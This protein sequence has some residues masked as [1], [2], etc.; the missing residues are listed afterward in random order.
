MKSHYLIGPKKIIVKYLDEQAHETLRCGECG[1]GGSGDQ[2][3]TERSHHQRELGC[4]CCGA[5][6][7]LISEVWQGSLGTGASNAISEDELTAT[8]GLQTR[9]GVRIFDA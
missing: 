2:A 9:G 3:T 1:W 8:L 5:M 4:P 7:A 6:I